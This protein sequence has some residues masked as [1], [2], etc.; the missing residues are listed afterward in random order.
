MDDDLTA[1]DLSPEERLLVL[2]SCWLEDRGDGIKP[3]VLYDPERIRE[4]ESLVRL[5]WLDRVEV[6]DAQG[7]RQLAGYRLSARARTSHRLATLIEQAK[8]ATN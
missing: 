6:V 5:G 4:C 8:E 2:A 3:R 7:R 1:T